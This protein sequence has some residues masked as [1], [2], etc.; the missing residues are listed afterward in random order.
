MI[1]NLILVGYS[2]GIAERKETVL[3]DIQANKD[4]MFFIDDDRE[5]C[6]RANRLG[7]TTF[8]ILT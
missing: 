3:K 6:I 2:D 8:N 1:F 7:I 5:N 4:I